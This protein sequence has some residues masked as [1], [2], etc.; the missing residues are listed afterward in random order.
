VSD[1]ISFGFTATEDRVYV[2]LL[3]AAPATGYTVARAAGLARAN[4]YAALEA[5]ARRGVATRIPGRPARWVAEDPDVLVERLASESRRH[6]EQ[7]G[8]T[9]ASARRPSASDVGLLEVLGG[10]A[11]VLDR[12]S[13]WARSAREE[14]LAVVGPWAS[15]VFDDLARPRATRVA[16]RLLSLGTPGPAGAA[17]RAVPREE[18]AGYWGGLP[19]ALVVDRRRAL[20]AL[21]ETPDASGVATTH[22]AVVPFL[23]H[24]L[25]RELAAG[26]QPG[27]KRERSHGV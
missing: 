23:R 9:L 8:R 22:P 25:R 16:V 21:V 10:K 20:C 2:A 11:A 12:V 26:E 4:A 14:L 24:L 15:D 3:G 17:V 19:I 18:I 27:L 6:L 5:L 1:L 13:A 7:L